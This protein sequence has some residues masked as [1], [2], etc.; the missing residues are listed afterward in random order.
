MSHACSLHSV[1]SVLNLLQSPLHH[2]SINKPSLGTMT[3]VVIFNVT[4]SIAYIIAKTYVSYRTCVHHSLKPQVHH[5]G[6]CVPLPERGFGCGQSQGHQAH[7]V[8]ERPPSGLGHDQTREACGGYD[9]ECDASRRHMVMATVILLPVRCVLAVVGA[10]ARGTV[11]QDIVVW[12]H[13]RE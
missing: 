12:W 13:G 6:K 10:S 2:T 4:N 9:G 11:A 7:L 5:I 1:Y 8:Q 3:L